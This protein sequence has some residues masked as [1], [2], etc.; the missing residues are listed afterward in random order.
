MSLE[1]SSTLVQKNKVSFVALTPELAFDFIKFTNYSFR[2]YLGLPL[3]PFAQYSY[4]GLFTVNGYGIGA[5]V[6]AEM[7]LKLKNSFGLHFDAGYRFLKLFYRLPSDADVD[8]FNPVFN[9]ARFSV[10]LSYAY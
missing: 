5:S 4:D 6:G 8:E 3:V 1:S 10:A 9:G 2:G 7:E